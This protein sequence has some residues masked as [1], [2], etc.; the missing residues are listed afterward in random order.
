MENFKK[1]S[2]VCMLWILINA[3]TYFIFFETGYIVSWLFTGLFVLSTVLLIVV[4]MITSF[5]SMMVSILNQ[6]TNKVKKYLFSQFVWFCFVVILLGLQIQVSALFTY[7]PSNG[8]TATIESVELNGTTQYMSIRGKDLSNP[9][10]LFLAGGP[11]G[12]QMS[13]TREFLADLED[14]YTIVNWDQPGVGKS[15][16]ARPYKDLTV[17]LYIEDAHALTAYL[18]QKYNQEKIYIMGES[19]GSYL[20]ILL[21][22]MFP[23]DYYAFI[24]S[25]QMVDFT[26]TEITCYNL[27]ME[28]AVE[29]GDQRQIDALNKIGIPPIYGDNVTMDIGTYLQYLYMH[30]ERDSSI[31]QVNWDT[32]DSLFSPEYSV[33][34]SVNFARGLFFTFS[35]VYQQLYG[36][37]LR[38]EYTEFDIPIYILHGRHDVNA[39]VY[40]VES[41]FELIQ[42]PEKE[43]IFFEHSGHNPWINESQLFNET[44]EDL[45]DLH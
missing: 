4:G 23:E 26:E 13:S 7:S 44:V 37:D 18:K 42:A 12:T 3:I 16:N 43:L 25:G 32:F 31:H 36:T 41:Y 38:E 28:I 11:G 39:P 45:F 14:T 33:M 8:G 40:L 24:G 17:D 22:S 29:K 30:M 21:S 9:V 10:I 35:H 34:D 1:I 6:G 15:Y 2:A 27:A 19:W 5:V 20:G